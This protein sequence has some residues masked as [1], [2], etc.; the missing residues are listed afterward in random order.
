M[1]DTHFFLGSWRRQKADNN[2]G[3]GGNKYHQCSKIRVMDVQK[4]SGSCFRFPAVRSGVRQIYTHPDNAAGV[5]DS[6]PPECTLN[7][8]E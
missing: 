2:N 7:N 6:Y 4:Y 8:T 1:R 3:D 5:T